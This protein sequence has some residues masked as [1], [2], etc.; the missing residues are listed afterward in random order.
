MNHLFSLDTFSIFSFEHLIIFLFFLFLT[1]IIGFYGYSVKGN[2]KSVHFATKILISVTIIQEICDYL[3][4][5]FNGSL[6]L[7]VDLPFHICNYVLF[8][9]VIALYNKNEYLFNFCYFNA[10]SGA[11][12]A[13]LTPDTE[14]VV[15]D[16]G[17]FF[18][19]FHHF[20]II[21]NVVWMLSALQMV[22][23][24]KGVVST[25]IMLNIFALPIGLI[26]LLIGDG[27][28]YMYL[29]A[30]PPVENPLLIGQWPTYIFALEIIGFV[31]FLILLLPFKM[32]KL[33]NEY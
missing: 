22:P 21:I 17:L 10:F 9:S 25:A 11:L 8:L 2:I 7:S 33:A 15:G 5:Y 30:P 6:S 18:F 14:G 3:N 20:L 26:N 1:F 31:I 13:N 12:V 32:K 29:C 19:F 23:T 27:A 16:L 24:I 28:N 4:R